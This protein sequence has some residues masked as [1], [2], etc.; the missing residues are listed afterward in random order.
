MAGE[1]CDDP[2]ASSLLDMPT[3]QWVRLSGRR[4]DLALEP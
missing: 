2:P 3:Q 1:P 4:V